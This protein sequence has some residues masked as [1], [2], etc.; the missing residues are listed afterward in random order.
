MIIPN[1]EQY[2]MLAIYFQCFENAII[3][4]REYAARYP[5]RMR[6]SKHVFISLARRLRHNGCGQRIPA[7]RR[8]RRPARNEDNVINVLA[9]V[10]AD[11]HISIRQISRDLDVSYWCIQKILSEHKLHPYHI[12]LHQALTNEDF[13]RRM[14][15]CQRIIVKFQEDQNFLSKV[16]WT[17]E[18]TFSNIG[19][20]N[21]HN[22]HYWS[23]NN[24]HWM[25]QIDHQHRWSV[26]VWCGII[27]G[28]IIG[29][30]VFNDHLNGNR[31]LEFLEN[32]LPELLENVPLQTRI[33]MWF[34]HDGC[35]AH[36]A[37][38][39]RELLDNRFPNRWIGRGSLFS[40]PPRSPD[41]TCL[42]F[43]LW[44]RI[45]DLV[46]QT[47]PTN[48]EDLIERIRFAI[49][50]ISRAEIEAAVASTSRRIHLCLNHD[51]QHFEQFL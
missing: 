42:D 1:E 49:N 3:A 18:A 27:D 7:A 16:L 47:R 23:R 41:L 46:Y 5:G 33:D 20:V 37:R 36:F 28:Q 38:N 14:I 10:E 17:D 22:M 39:V 25:E 2:D 19:K 31:Y 4:S 29:P 32:D 24:P 50:S 35:P 30:F 15:F 45:K 21:R 9:I 44:G 11:P 34:Q 40:W 8:R 12:Q 26:N 6:R 48:R 51:G 13:N 43:Y